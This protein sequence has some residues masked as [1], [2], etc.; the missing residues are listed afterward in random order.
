MKA[1][2]FSIYLTVLF[3]G[4]FITDTKGDEPLSVINMQTIFRGTILIQV[5]LRQLYFIPSYNYTLLQVILAI[6]I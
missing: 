1:K 6:L 3:L 2:S 4:I 5:I